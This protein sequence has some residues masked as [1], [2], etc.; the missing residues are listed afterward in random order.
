MVRRQNPSRL[1]TQNTDFIL[2]KLLLPLHSHSPGG[3][4]VTREC[5]VAGSG[6]APTLIIAETPLDIY[7][8]YRDRIT[9][10]DIYTLYRDKPRHH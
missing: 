9:P 8:L 5:E 1:M 7:T 10:L 2:Q 6:Q 3:W 4:W